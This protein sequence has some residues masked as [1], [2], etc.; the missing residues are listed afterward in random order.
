MAE[1]TQSRHRR[2][3]EQ[4]DAARERAELGHADA[5]VLR[6]QSLRRAD[7]RRRPWRLTVEGRVKEPP[8]PGP[9]KN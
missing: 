4:R 9:G 5:S 3:G 7:A 2:A 6:P 8:Q 1:A